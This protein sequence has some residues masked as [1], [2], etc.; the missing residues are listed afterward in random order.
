MGRFLKVTPIYDKM[1]M[2]ALGYS[3]LYFN[4]VVIG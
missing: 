3:A 4:V 1:L 2:S